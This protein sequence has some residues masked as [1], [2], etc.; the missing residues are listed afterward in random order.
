MN[1]S[2][3]TD[4]NSALNDDKEESKESFE[5]FIRF[6]HILLYYA[7]DLKLTDQ[8]ETTLDVKKREDSLR[9]MISFIMRYSLQD[10]IKKD[11]SH[12]NPKDK[13]KTVH[14]L[15]IYYNFNE[16]PVIKEA[17]IKLL[18]FIKEEI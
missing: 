9:D 4:N 10:S 13:R 8:K 16:T 15:K 17:L 5:R 18:E 11:F 12:I 2:A 1:Y 3:I 14:S 6:C 7:Y